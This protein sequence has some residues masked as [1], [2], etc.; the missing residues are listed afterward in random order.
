MSPILAL[1][2]LWQIGQVVSAGSSGFGC[3]C[4]SFRFLRFSSSSAHLLASKAVNPSLMLVLH[5]FLS[6]ALDSQLLKSML[7]FFMLAFSR[8]LGLFFYPPLFRLPSFS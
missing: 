7:H 5:S 4:P 3:C 6:K 2:V 8:S 1:N